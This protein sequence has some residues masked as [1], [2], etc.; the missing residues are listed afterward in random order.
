[1]SVDNAAENSPSLQLPDVLI[2]PLRENTLGA[3]FV[4]WPLSLATLT[5]RTCACFQ[6]RVDET[7]E[8]VVAPQDHM[9]AYHLTPSAVT[10]ES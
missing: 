2:P 3:I 7:D 10:T 6:C 8:G 5:A 1:M 9:S 4:T